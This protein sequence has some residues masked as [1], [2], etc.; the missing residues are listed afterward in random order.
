MAH[1]FIVDETTLPVHLQYKFA[2]TGAKNYNCSYLV[3]NSVE[4]NANIE[5]VLTEM[6]ADIYRVKK[7]DKILFYLQKS[8]KH[9]GMFFGSFKA[10]E[11]AFLC[12]DKYLNN[13]L[14]KNLTFRVLIE[15][16]EVY[17]Q[18]ITERECLDSLEGITHPSQM[19]W[20]LIYRKLNG[21]RGCTM[22]TNYEYDKIMDKI[23]LKNN[24][25]KLLGNNFDYYK[26]ESK[27]ISCSHQAQYNGEKQSLNILNR[28]VYK[29]LKRG[30]YETHLQAYILQN[31]F[32]INILK[33]NNEKIVWI[34][35]E[36]SCGVGMQ[37]IDICLIQENNEKADIII[38]EL[39]DEQPKEYINNQLLK[40][41]DWIKDYIIPQYNKKVIIHPTIIAPPPNKKTK[42]IYQQIK[43]NSSK[44][45]KNYMVEEIRYISFK[46]E[47]KAIIFEE[48]K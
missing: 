20:S 3:D 2:G 35:N 8:A 7:E 4:I 44:I 33:V 23:R 40:Y 42:N 37:S 16:D 17:E 15:P 46:E 13:R 43:E 32:D 10:I 34:G 41:I 31:I 29:K 11:N 28:L 1:V 19:C 25:K 12:E 36:V 27:L 24:N 47:N 6:I 30:S 18:G 14:E 9:E 38:C 48:E 39:K 26:D 21:N 5:R 22:I 45:E